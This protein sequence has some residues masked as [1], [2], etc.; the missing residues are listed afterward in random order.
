MN[1]PVLEEALHL[2][3]LGFRLFPVRP[4][5][6][7]R[8]RDWQAAS[9]TDP[10]VV[11]AWWIRWPD[12]LIGLPCGPNNDLFVADVDVKPW[13]DAT[14][15]WDWLDIA[16]T[17]TP[18][19]KTPSG[20]QHRYYSFGISGFGNSASFVGP[21]VDT[22]GSGG[23]V[24]APP[25]VGL[26][27]NGYRWVDGLTII[28]RT[29][30]PAALAER[31]NGGSHKAL[32]AASKAIYTAPEGTRND[33]LNAQ[34]FSLF[35]AGKWDTAL[36]RLCLGHAARSAGLDAPE[37]DA[38]LDSAMAAATAKR[39]EKAKAASAP[40]FGIAEIA[41]WPEIVDGGLLIRELCE[42]VRHYVAIGEAR[43]IGVALWTIATYFH[44]IA[45]FA[46][47]LAILSPMMRCG[48]TTLLR[49]VGELVPRPLRTE[50]ISAAALY[51][52]A[53]AMQPTFLLDEADQQLDPKLPQGP[54]LRQ[55]L[56]GGYSRGGRI[57]RMAGEGSSMVPVQFNTFCPVA[58]AG[59][60]QVKVPQLA[61][62]SLLI[63]LQ[64]RTQNER[65]ARFDE[66]RLQA[67][68]TVRAKIARFAADSMAV[69]E[70]AS[71]IVEAPQSLNDRQA[72]NWRTMLAVAE[73]IGG[74]WPKK[75]RQVA[76][77]LS[78]HANLDDDG[79]VGLLLLGDC[80][81]VFETLEAKPDDVIMTGA[82]INHLLKIEEHGW[83][84]ARHPLTDR[85]LAR[86]LRPFG[87]R[88]VNHALRSSG[89]TVRNVRKAYR[90]QPFLEAWSR[91][92]GPTPQY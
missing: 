11:T 29:P 86:L 72:D 52:L 81:T 44:E 82:L 31:L 8:V 57:V 69:V 83:D 14:L 56:L 55:V 50:G 4:D 2:A 61:D 28:D 51:R 84:D 66:R 48:K 45:T 90:W 6:H 64:R 25:S 3:D 20:G 27:G 74:E 70:A 88:S 85:K 91:Y 35:K 46:P 77:T 87:I 80:R 76:A 36:V 41:P 92:L 89:S 79:D 58:L 65:V 43:L 12:A 18:I 33:T 63:P 32:L 40:D 39:T 54:E 59:I 10:E 30:I 38:T 21:G 17:G 49:V 78:A 19:A 26:D 62:R 68:H 15:V 9:T 23:F 5:K 22:R 24:I 71:A 67:L 47:R 42:A 34:A 73:V 37:I 1:N 7:P 16:D 60:G 13:L 75:A 53:E